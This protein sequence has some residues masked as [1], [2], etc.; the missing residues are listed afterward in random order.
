MGTLVEGEKGKKS[1]LTYGA[2]DL[3]G[4]QDEVGEGVLGAGQ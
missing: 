4:V 1:G 3:V 2:G